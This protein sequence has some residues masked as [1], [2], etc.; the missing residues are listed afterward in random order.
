MNLKRGM[1]FG[2]PGY[3]FHEV[4]AFVRVNSHSVRVTSQPVQVI[5]KHCT[6]CRL[7]GPRGPSA[8]PEKN[9]FSVHNV[10]IKG[11]IV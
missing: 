7:C 4:H 3:V 1:Y 11:K 9:T 10:N 2:N 6:F 8:S 5:S